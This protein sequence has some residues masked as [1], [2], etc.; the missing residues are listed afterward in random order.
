MAVLTLI[1]GRLRVDNGALVLSAASDNPCCCDCPTACT[2]SESGLI[3]SDSGWSVTDKNPLKIPKNL[4]IS[5][6]FK[7]EDSA[8]CGGKNGN[9]QSGNLSCCF[10]L[11][12]TAEIEIEVSGNVETQ[13]SGY[14]ISTL[15]LNGVV[16]TIGSFNEGG[17]CRMKQTSNKNTITLSAG[18]HTYSLTTSTN[19]ALYHAGMTHTFKISK[20]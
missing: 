5:I 11:N 3:S 6:N 14:D 19:D 17:G 16:A 9:I 7:F 10:Y 18:V 4:P 12:A 8:I 1:D 13:N 15:S 20:K 2:L